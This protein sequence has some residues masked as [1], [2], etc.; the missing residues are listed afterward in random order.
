MTTIHVLGPVSLSRAGERSSVRGQQG[1]V[2]SVLVAAYPAAVRS[3]R[4][5]DLLWG[6]TQPKT[7]RT[8][9]GV[10]IHRLRDRLGTS[11]L[12]V[13]EQDAYRLAVEPGQLDTEQFAELVSA[14]QAHLD[15]G[16]AS[17]ALE[18]LTAALGLWA[19][20]AFQPFDTSESLR[21]ESTA[22]AERQRA[23]EELLLDALLITGRSDDAAAWASK[24]VRSA[25]YREQR[26]HGLALALYRSN[27]QT[28][29]LRTMADA[30][31]TLRDDIG[32]DPS[33]TLRALERDILEQADHLWLV[34]AAEPP[35]GVA[36]TL[37][38]SIAPPRVGDPDTSFIGRTGDLERV[39]DQLEARRFVTIV[40]EAGAG[41]TRVAARYARSVATRVIWVDLAEHRADHVVGALSNQLGLTSPAERQLDSLARELRVQ[42]TLV[43][44][45]NCEHVANA[46]GG[47]ADVIISSDPATQVLATSRT[48]LGPAGET[49]LV[50][51]PL[52][53]EA[54][55]RLLVERAFGGGSAP[56]V[57]EQAINRLVEKLGANPLLIELVA[58]PVRS[59]SVEAVDAELE[60]VLTQ[61][62]ARGADL[63]HTSLTAAL[64]WS[65]DLLDDEHQQLHATLGVM[66]GGFSAAEVA[67]ITKQDSTVIDD[68]LASLCSHGLLT[69]DGAS[70][71][72]RYRQADAVGIH[73]RHRLQVAGRVHDTAAT[74]TD[75]FFELL[76]ELAPELWTEHEPRAV[77][78]LGQVRGQLAVTHE[79][80]VSAGDVGRAA[81]FALA[82]WDYAFLR[83]DVAAFAMLADVLKMDGVSELDNYGEILGTAAVA[84]WARNDFYESVRLADEAVALAGD[85][86]SPVSLQALRARFNVASFRELHSGPMEAFGDLINATIER[87]TPHLR[88]DLQVL[89]TLGL[90]Q[91]GESAG[92][93]DAARRGMAI[94]EK[95]ANPSCLAWAI[96]AVGW[97]KLD[98]EPTEAARHFVA[99]A[100]TARTVRNQF[101]EAMAKGALVTSALRRGRTTQARRLLVEVISMWNRLESTPQLIRACREAVL[102]LA[103][104]GQIDRASSALGRVELL[105]LGHPLPPV[106]QQ[107]FDALAAEI[108]PSDE[109]VGF[110]PEE[111]LAEAIIE[112]LR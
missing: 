47:L 31:R 6:D 87:G 85:Q 19:G 70:S 34:D 36:E 12:I 3:D 44:L 72:I 95:T 23:A 96:Y 39:A 9:L 52:S 16:A 10:V 100:R 53:T 4:L 42:P 14:A 43:V 22:L 2:L 83:L 68:G 112:L 32:V 62:T 102:V 81:E 98:D 69:T 1:E 58:E 20:E 108:G 78:R 49:C 73:A 56:H 50:L 101:V 109:P 63:R 77:E 57:D 90:S 13:T 30:F 103:D 41:K 35:L 79:R 84:A 107:R 97:S 106:D 99:A 8:G 17:S 65:V 110:D 93:T 75:A 18:P 38:S 92:A 33:P 48:A 51:P 37:T 40:G 55:A 54:G 76:C 7:A 82:M 59:L 25:P 67:R 15:A 105:D 91:I 74:H 11:A 71:P 86:D 24:L 45:D 28:E 29:A 46:A 89:L 104:E 94:A 21:A 66:R 27:R 60:R 26:W 88:S 64:D 61:S 5:I 111:T 80:L